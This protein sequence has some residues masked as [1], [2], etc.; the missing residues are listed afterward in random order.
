M[1]ATSVV[2]GRVQHAFFAGVADDLVV[3]RHER[4]REKFGHVL[5]DRARL[6]LVQGRDGLQRQLGR[7]LALGV[8]AHAVGQHKQARFAR[9][10]IAHAVFV[11]FAPP[12][13]LIWK[14]ENFMARPISAW[15]Q[16]LLRA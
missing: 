1:A 6:F 14:T 11:L 4:R 16:S 7:D 15:R 10:A 2:R 13:R 3:R 5:H 12:L 8:A 9:V